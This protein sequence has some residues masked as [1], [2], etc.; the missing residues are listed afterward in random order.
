M[1]VQNVG[2]ETSVFINLP[3][4]PYKHDDPDKYRLPLDSKLFGYS[5]DK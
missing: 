5:F 3:T 1:R 2:K 4:R